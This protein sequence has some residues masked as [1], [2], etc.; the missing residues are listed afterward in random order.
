[1]EGGGWT[2]ETQVVSRIYDGYS[3]SELNLGCRSL[4]AKT[5]WWAVI[6]WL[7]IL[8][9]RKVITHDPQDTRYEIQDTMARQANKRFF[10]RSGADCGEGFEAG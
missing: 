2:S 5:F 6:Q 7:G 10:V 4:I 9:V 8:R 3:G 1:M